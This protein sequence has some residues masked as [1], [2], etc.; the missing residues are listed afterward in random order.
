GSSRGPGVRLFSAEDGKDLPRPP[1]MTGI[2]L[3]AVALGPNG[4]LATAGAS[5]DTARENTV[6]LWDLDNPNPR[7]PLASFKP[8]QQ[9]MTFQMRFNPQGTLLALV[10][11]G[12]IELWDPAAHLLVTVLRMADQ[13]ADLAFSPDGRTLAAG[14]RSASSLTWTVLDSTARTQLSGFDARISSLAF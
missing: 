14:G 3:S 2:E 13:P 10:G 8:E 12:P 6:K 5:T 9:H 1:I 11:P 4:L 7:A